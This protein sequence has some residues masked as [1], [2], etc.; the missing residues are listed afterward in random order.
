MIKDELKDRMITVMGLG[1]HGGGIATARFLAEAGARV[2][3]TDLRPRT[4]L[5]PSIDKL[6]GLDIRFILGEHR[7]EDFRDSYM[8]IKNPAVPS[9]SPYLK[10]SR[11]IETDISLFLQ[12]VSNP[13]I[14]VTGSKGKSTTV[15]AIYHVMQSVN[16]RTRL[17]GNITVS[18][19]T[20]V[21]EL[22]KNDPVILELSSWQL[23]DLGER[24]LLNPEIAVITNIMH[25]HQ[26]RYKRFRDY[27]ED[28]KLIFRNQQSGSI[29]LF[30]E[31][32]W[33]NEFSTETQGDV[34]RFYQERP[35]PDQMHRSG[36]LEK[37]RGWYSEDGINSEELVPLELKVPGEHFRLNMLIAAM[38][39][40][41][42]GLTPEI[43]RSGLSSFH[44]IPHRMEWFT[45]K[46][47]VRFYNDSA[48][49]IP[50]AVAAA[51]ESFEKKPLL[52]AGGTDKELDF[53]V[54]GKGLGHCKEIFLLEGSGT[55]KIIPVL[56]SHGIKWKGPYSSLEEALNKAYEK[57]VEGD[58]IIL[59]PGCTSFGMFLNEFV[60]GDRFRELVYAL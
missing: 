53:Q 2:T 36:W 41:K 9:N 21:N 42:K 25:D 5:Q 29:S 33:A 45:T 23:H 16:P 7:E 50:E 19:L 22:E 35:D 43:I 27:V 6:A 46:N 40:R 44:G 32:N 20:F 34:Y 28:K 47:G 48:A 58:S 39:L 59:S 14:A 38:V 26:N 1:L 31:D 56:Q 15:S 12:L 3:V 51:V 37:G 11:Q 60:R 24:D 13:V 8:V 30:G 17:G 55:D 54:L 49:T 4:T 18:P 57:A 10:M 52:I